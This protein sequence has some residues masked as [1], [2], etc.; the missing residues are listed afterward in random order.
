MEE[1]Q[2]AE[3]VEK[4]RGERGKTGYGQP[5]KTGRRQSRRREGN[6]KE[7]EMKGEGCEE[8]EKEPGRGHQRM[9]KLCKD[10]EWDQTESGAL[11]TGSSVPTESWWVQYS[12]STT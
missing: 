11:D 5:K 4:M 12:S 1:G 2:K 6:R 9:S 3:N 8:G 7:S 10:T